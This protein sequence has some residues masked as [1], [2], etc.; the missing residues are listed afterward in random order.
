LGSQA[1]REDALVD[2]KSAK[3]VARM[4]ARMAAK[5]A[6]KM[7]CR[8]EGVAHGRDPQSAVVMD[9]PSDT[10]AAC[11]VAGTGDPSPCRVGCTEPAWVEDY[12]HCVVAWEVGMRADTEHVNS[13]RQ[14]AYAKR[15]QRAERLKI[16]QPLRRQG[17]AQQEW[18]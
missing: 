8:G 16:L 14:V 7:A 9:E 5:M 12:M 2:A 3:V 4:A 13:R 17:L 10:A 18:V 15:R 11:P 1:D 6:A